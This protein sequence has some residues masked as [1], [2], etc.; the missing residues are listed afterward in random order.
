MYH[1]ALALDTGHD[2]RNVDPL[3]HSGSCLYISVEGRNV[4]VV[5]G[6]LEQ[7]AILHAEPRTGRVATVQNRRAALLRDTGHGPSEQALRVRIP[8]TDQPR[9]IDYKDSV[10]SA[11]QHSVE[12]GFV[13][14]STDHPR[15][16][17]HIDGIPVSYTHL[18]L[19]T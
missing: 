11:L 13:H 17:A 1:Q 18:T 14:R 16:T 3:P 19:P 12:I 4:R 7:G 5:A 15:Q 10:A 8:K 2:D 6:D 9:L